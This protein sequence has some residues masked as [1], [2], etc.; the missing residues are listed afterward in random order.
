MA[1]ML[2]HTAFNLLTAPT[3]S[4]LRFEAGL[5]EIPD[6]LVTHWYVAEHATLV[7]PALAEAAPEAVEPEQEPE[8]EVVADDP[9]QPTEEPQEP[10]TDAPEPEA[11]PADWTGLHWTQKV[12]LA[13]R[14]APE[15]ADIDSQT[16]GDIIAAEVE[17]R[18]N[19]QA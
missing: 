19:G 1:Q 13:K 18:A 5:Q 12:A 2:V 16:A 4:P 9:P 11:I 17:R 8:A 15:A 14:L 3:S 7:G 10:V 6:D